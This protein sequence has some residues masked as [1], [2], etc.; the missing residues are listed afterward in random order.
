MQDDRGLKGI[1]KAPNIYSL[2]QNLIGA[3]Y[4]RRWWIRNI[5][6]PQP[7]EKVIDIGCGPGDVLDLL[8]ELDYY[9]IDISEKYIREAQKRYGGR[10]VFLHGDTKACAGDDRLK[11]AD[12]VMCI[13]VLHHLDDPEAEQALAFAKSN[14][15]PGGRFVGVEPCLLAHQSG[16][17]RWV[18]SRDRGQNVRREAEWQRLLSYQF[19]DCTTAVMAGMIRLPYIHI[20][21]TGRHSH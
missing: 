7:G 1:F 2:F 21:L 20:A 8:P 12:L 13:G 14:L 15:K 6:C 5:L 19:P 16:L 4:A 9:G 3:Q 18:M 17:S 10:G 11:N